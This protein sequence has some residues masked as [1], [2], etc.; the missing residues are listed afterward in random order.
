MAV[1]AAAA[2]FRTTNPR[3]LVRWCMAKTLTEALLGV[4]VDL[5]TPGNLPARFREQVLAAHGP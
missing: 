5:L 2:R 1:R 3:V 4:P